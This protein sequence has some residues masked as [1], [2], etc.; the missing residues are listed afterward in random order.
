MDGNLRREFAAAGT[1]AIFGLLYGTYAAF[2]L[3][4]G[5]FAAMGA[6]MFPLIVGFLVFIL[7]TAHGVVTYLA[8]R[9]A[10][11]PAAKEAEPVQWHSLAVV[12]ASMAAFYA[13]I[14]VFG[15]MPAIVFLTIATTVVLAGFTVTL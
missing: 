3:P 15:L 11:A 8:Y 5:A 2:F 13:G 10:S 1:L 14:K 7:G 6:G 9:R 4:I 12:V